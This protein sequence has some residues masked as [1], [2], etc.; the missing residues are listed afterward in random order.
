MPPKKK[1]KPKTAPKAVDQDVAVDKPTRAASSKGKQRA[2]EVLDGEDGS[3]NN[4]K[5]GAAV[6]DARTPTTQRREQWQVAQEHNKTPL[7]NTRPARNTKLRKKVFTLIGRVSCLVTGLRYHPHFL[8]VAHIVSRSLSW[9]HWHWYEALRDD[10]GI[11][12]Y[13]NKKFLKK[14]LNLDTS[15]N[16][17]IL[18]AWLHLLFDGTS[19]RKNIGQG[20]IAF[21]PENLL[22]IL[23]N[24]FNNNGKRNYRELAPNATY[25]YKLLCFENTKYFYGRFSD[26]DRNYD[27]LSKE[28]QVRKNEEEDLQLDEEHPVAPD[29]EVGT[30]HASAVI[31]PEDVPLDKS[32]RNGECKE[33]TLKAGEQDFIMERFMN[34]YLVTFDLMVKMN[35][36]MENPELA[37]V[38][39]KKWVKL[40]KTEMKRKTAHWFPTEAEA[41]AK[42]KANAAAHRQAQGRTTEN[43]NRGQD[44]RAP[45]TDERPT[46]PSTPQPIDGPADDSSSPPPSSPPRNEPSSSSP[47]GVNVVDFDRA[48]NALVGVQQLDLSTA[49]TFR[50][51]SPAAPPSRQ[52]SPPV[53]PDATFDDP[54]AHSS[55]SER[56]VGVANH[57]QSLPERPRQTRKLPKRPGKSNPPPA[58][59]THPPNAPRRASLEDAKQPDHLSAQ[60]AKAPDKVQGSGDAQ[61]DAY[62]T[63]PP[64]PKAPDKTNYAAS[65]TPTSDD[66]DAPDENPPPPLRAEGSL[67]T[68]PRAP[69]APDKVSRAKAP[70]PSMPPP[71]A[72]PSTSTAQTTGRRQTRAAAKRALEEN[73]A[74]GVDTAEPEPPDRLPDAPEPLRKKRRVNTSDRP[75]EPDIERDHDPPEPSY[76]ARRVHFEDRLE[77]PDIERDHDPPSLKQSRRRGRNR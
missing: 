5:R 25:K 44:Y 2:K 19:V 12:V 50:D 56:A 67:I 38:I 7:T 71:T 24:I 18:C 40:Y 66:P 61:N 74:Q 22:E 23:N 11:S 65:R 29:G 9:T 8:H 43:S 53:L 58:T 15:V 4:D 59:S 34:P 63:P 17:E 20:P 35:Y 14:V 28:P 49:D 10:I 73:S 45:V 54:L 31:D 32:Y 70:E 51:S 30:D 46:M 42:K 1:K 76:D 41:L 72:G 16:Q 57:A 55:T 33:M 3:G 75:K 36:R 60:E 39:P 69:K 64:V 6:K 13:R 47:P 26:V 37:D 62:A 27:H 77:E 48:A 52:A 68:L 21:V